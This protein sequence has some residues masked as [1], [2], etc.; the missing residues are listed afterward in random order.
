ML[1]RVFYISSNAIQQGI[2]FPAEENVYPAVLI[3]PA[4]T[5]AL[6]SAY[7]FFDENANKP[8]VL[9]LDLQEEPGRDTLR[10]LASFTFLPAM[11]RMEGK[12]VY[13]LF[14]S[15]PEV[16]KNSETQLLDIL[17][18]QGFDQAQIF[19]PQTNF[20]DAPLFENTSGLKEHYKHMLHSGELAGKNIFV[21]VSDLN[22]MIG[23]IEELKLLEK[24]FE[25]DQPDLFTSIMC[26]QK[27]EHELKR[28]RAQIDALNRELEN[29][30]EY[31]ELLRSNHSTRELQEYYNREY[32]VLPTW[33][34][35]L[36]HIVKVLTG[37]RNF[38]SL[39]RDDVKKYKD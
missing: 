38:R 3:N 25:A 12:P 2:R 20:A 33:F 35:R 22:G 18:G 21:R 17:A 8:M 32:E 23:S 5:V 1:N 28:S 29:Q 36:G 31:N 15:S 34:K 14:G 30:K 4:D 11:L 27:L 10:L 13:C 26:A 37:K 7:R 16:I 39:Y 9:A 6:H 24:E 19:K